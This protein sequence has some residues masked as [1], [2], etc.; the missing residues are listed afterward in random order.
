MLCEHAIEKT[1]D[2]KLICW[3]CG[4]FGIFHYGVF[5]PDNEP[6]TGVYN[7]NQLNWECVDY[8][9]ICLDCGNAIHEFEQMNPAA[10]IAVFAHGMISRINDDF[11]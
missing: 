5:I 1:T 4:K 10:V 6:T 2:G 3:K 8:D 11:I 9:F 7:G